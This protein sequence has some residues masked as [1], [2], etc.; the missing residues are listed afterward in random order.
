MSVIK[1][2]AK[3]AMLS[4]ANM[5]LDGKYDAGNIASALEW[6]WTD[7]AIGV[8]EIYKIM[9]YNKSKSVIVLYETEERILISEPFDSLFERW[10]KLRRDEVKA[11]NDKDEEA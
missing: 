6:Q 2:R 11:E 7:L 3:Q 9:A 1:L 10:D 8:E 5:E 4:E